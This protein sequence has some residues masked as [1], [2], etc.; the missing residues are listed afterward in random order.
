MT[1]GQ[2]EYNMVYPFNGILLNNEENIKDMCYYMNE[3]RKQYAKKKEPLRKDHI[4]WFHSYEI[5]IIGK[6]IQKEKK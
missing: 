1:N 2:I 6:A 3:P 4:V 5:F